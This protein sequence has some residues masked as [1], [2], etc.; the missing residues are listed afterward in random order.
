MR[1]H[2]QRKETRGKKVLFGLW[3]PR[4]EVSSR[5]TVQS[6]KRGGRDNSVETFIKKE[7]KATSAFYPPALPFSEGGGQR[8]L[9]FRGTSRASFK[10]KKSQRES[11][12]RRC[13]EK[14]L[15]G[16]FLLRIVAGV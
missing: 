13:S 11:H 15:K 7:G 6:E 3:E 10:G 2:H 12:G 8:R 4:L 16:V 14:E 1:K 5:Q 9:T